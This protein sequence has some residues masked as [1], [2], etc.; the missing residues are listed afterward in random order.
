VQFSPHYFEDP[1][2]RIFA[3]FL[4][5]SIPVFFNG[6]L[7]NHPVEH[8]EPTMRFEVDYYKLCNTM[9]PSSTTANSNTTMD[10]SSADCLRLILAHLTENSLHETARTLQR[11]SGVGM[12]ASLTHNWFQ[13]AGTG[14]W[15][16]VLQGLAVLD[17][18]RAHLNASLLAGVHEM[19]I[20]ELAEAG[21]WNTAYAVFR[22]LQ[23]DDSMASA[24]S[25]LASSSSKSKVTVSRSLEQKLAQ[26]AA[27]RQKDKDCAVPDDFYGSGSSK[28][29]RREELGQHLQDG[30]PRQPSQRL[31]TLI[32]QAIKWQAYTGQIPRIRQWWPDE[33]DDDDEGKQDPGDDKSRSH[34]KKKR[35]RKEFDLVLGEV[36]VDPMTVG[37]DIMGAA[38]V[39]IGKHIT[40]DYASISF[41][42]KS[43][44]E[45]AAFLTDG[46]G[47]VTGSSDGL[48]EIWDSKGKLRTDL[49]YQANDDLLGHDNGSGVTSLSISNDG[50]LLASG[51]ADGTVN[52]WRMDTGKCL[53][54]IETSAAKSGISCLAFS[55]QGSHILTASHDGTCREFGLRTARMLKEFRGH[56]SYLTSCAYQLIDSSSQ[57]VVL[58][59]SGDGT[60]RIWNG[61]TA[62]MLRI[63]QP[64]SLGKHLSASGASIVLAEMS[65]TDRP[66]IHGL[67]PLH[68]PT[69][70]MVVV[71]RGVRAFLVD[72]SGVILQTFQDSSSSDKVFVASTVSATNR[73]LY[74]VKEEG[75]CCVF[76]V[77]TGKLEHTIRE[78]GALSTSSSGG[79]AAE[80]SSLIHHCYKDVIAAFS[81]EKGQKKGK[82]V[83]WK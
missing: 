33:E 6:G 73:W 20:L 46:T 19:A 23:Q 71:P 44:C 68:T 38:A 9:D 69:D 62:D 61:Q 17:R 26:L 14:Q 48:I 55:P 12:A 24:F 41:G 47:L 78:F 82:L 2:L 76:D 65:T 13:Q 35:K 51:A 58:T 37:T 36:S 29:A 52:L 66:A 43:T 8:T 59:A 49:E 81:N 31:Q 60:V 56:T 80:V 11:E 74:A 4:F 16:T 54:S 25:D 64:V 75:S 53:R 83:L 40:E 10:I 27:A 67:H 57:L 1:S 72:Y 21:D 32:Q 30:V 50:Q 28:Q 34:K 18:E 42:K 7:E 15:A 22:L 45:S 39:P 3:I 77:A 5:S 63:L 79:A 70:T